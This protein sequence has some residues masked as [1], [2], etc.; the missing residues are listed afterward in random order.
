MLQTTVELL[1]EITSAGLGVF[2]GVW[3]F[4]KIE[5]K[6]RESNEKLMLTLN[7]LKETIN[8]EKKYTVFDLKRFA[9]LSVTNTVLNIHK[10]I[11]LVIDRNNIVINIEQI[12]ADI[13]IIIDRAVDDGRA[14]LRDDLCFSNDML[15][16]FFKNT[17]EM[18]NYAKRKTRKT[19][20]ETAV[21]LE[22]KNKLKK[23]LIDKYKKCEESNIFEFVIEL[24][25]H[26]VEVKNEYD[27][28]KRDVWQVFEQVLSKLE[29]TYAQ[30]R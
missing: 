26:N 9:R 25:Q 15:K 20:E 12:L 27:K 29:E 21:I 11:S 18:K 22:E 23:D 14:Y 4:L 24:E 13:D 7:E 30:M 1:P 16:D 28:L 2:I 5:P 6:S 3:Y 10:R 19:F 8:A 17:D